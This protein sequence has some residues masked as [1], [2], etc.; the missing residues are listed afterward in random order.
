MGW[1]WCNDLAHADATPTSPAWI[2]PISQGQSNN[3]LVNVLIFPMQHHTLAATTITTYQALPRFP[4]CAVISNVFTLSPSS[5]LVNI[6]IFNQSSHTTM[7]QFPNRI[8]HPLPQSMAGSFIRW[9]LSILLHSRLMTMVHHRHHH[10]HGQDVN[11]HNTSPP[12]NAYAAW[13]ILLRS[14]IWIFSSSSSFHIFV[15]RNPIISDF[16]LFLNQI[17]SREQKGRCS[18]F[19]L[20]KAYVYRSDLERKNWAVLKSTM[21]YICGFIYESS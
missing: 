12:L 6:A 14:K 8:S 4:M 15:F 20:R 18:H 11:D 2:C 9:L 19:L 3:Y 5:F 10:L 7:D 13:Y 21:P 1:L 17:A 16:L